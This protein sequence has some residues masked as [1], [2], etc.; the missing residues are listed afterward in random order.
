MDTQTYFIDVI[1]PLS[2]PNK[3]TYRVPKELNNDVEVGKRVIVQFG[4]TKFYTAIIYSVHHNPPKDYSAKYIESVIDEN[5]IIKSKQLEL[6]DWMVQYYVC[7]P[8]DVLNAAL[9]SGLKLT[10]TFNIASGF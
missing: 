6:W 2:V 10:S 9:P 7:N 5:P 3:F 1:I 4:K 8:G